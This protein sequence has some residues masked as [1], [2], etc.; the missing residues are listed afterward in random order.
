MTENRRFQRR[1]ENFSCLNCGQEVQGTGYTNHCP[2][3]L[4][5]LHVDVNPGDRQS[6]CKGP[7]EPVASRS[8]SGQASILHHCQRCG[9]KQWNRT[10]S[11][12]NFDLIVRL[13]A[14]PCDE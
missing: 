5:S 9:H 13:S 4:W 14:M 2:T 3:C 7:M 8:R 10:A 1:Q 11:E 12:D 6:E